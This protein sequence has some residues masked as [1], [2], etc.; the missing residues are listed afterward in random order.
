MFQNLFFE[1]S[2]VSSGKIKT[3]YKLVQLVT[4]LPDNYFKGFST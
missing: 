4:R 1:R 3:G 2:T